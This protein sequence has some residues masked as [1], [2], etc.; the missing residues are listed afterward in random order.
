VTLNQMTTA[1]PPLALAAIAPLTRLASTHTEPTRSD[2]LVAWP[3]GG[4]PEPKVQQYGA[5]VSAV[6]HAAMCA[7]VMLY[8]CVSRFREVQATRES[9]FKGGGAI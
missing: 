8:A 7:D 1:T 6:F 3:M 9:S 4:S 2:I 5:V